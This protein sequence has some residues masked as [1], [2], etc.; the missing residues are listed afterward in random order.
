MRSEVANTKA[1]ALSSDELAG[2]CFRIFNPS[3]LNSPEFKEDSVREVIIT[4]ILS[5]L[6]HT[7]SGS[8][9]VIRS[10]ALVHPFIYAGTRKL[11][12]TFR[13]SSTRAFNIRLRARAPLAT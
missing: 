2:P 3:L 11:H 12:H 7:P 1:Q 4:P 10:K 6:G 9:R 13:R 5:R 8:D